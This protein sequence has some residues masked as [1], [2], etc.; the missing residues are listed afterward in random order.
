[1]EVPA[2][3]FLSHDNKNE[4]LI[5]IGRML[6]AL[7]VA[8]LFPAGLRISIT[9]AISGLVAFGGSGDPDTSFAVISLMAGGP[10]IISLSIASSP[11]RGVMAAITSSLASIFALGPIVGI[12]LLLLPDTG[13]G[14]L[15]GL[16]AAALAMTLIP[17]TPMVI[18]SVLGG[19]TRS[20]RGYLGLSL[21]LIAGGGASVIFVL[22]SV[23]AVPNGLPPIDFESTRFLVVASVPF[24]FVWTSGIFMPEL[25]TKRTN[26]TGI[27]AWVVLQLTWFVL[28]FGAL[29]FRPN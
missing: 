26:R 2:Q 23:F 9:K 4:L 19:H 21:A 11:R 18:A 29:F 22:G 5:L 17:G 27:L 24:G 28:G 1:M 12:G 6:I 10:I 25:L 15:G 14:V 3:G 8:P 13:R 16:G 20:W 7:L